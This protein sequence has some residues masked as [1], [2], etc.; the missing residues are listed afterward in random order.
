MLEVKISDTMKNDI[1]NFLAKCQCPEGGFGGGPGQIA[2]L[3]TTYAAINSLCILGTEKAYNI[4]N[5]YNS[6][7]TCCFK[8][9]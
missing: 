1:A 5:R 8:M 3:A 2:H 7:V 9:V 6:N 4:I